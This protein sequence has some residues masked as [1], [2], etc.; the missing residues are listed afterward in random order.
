MNRIARIV[1][2]AA[3]LL[4]G[5]VPSQ[6]AA[7]GGGGCHGTPLTDDVTDE[8]K[9]TDACFVPTVARVRPGAKVTFYGEYME[10]NVTGVP[11]SFNA[12]QNQHILRDGT[13]LAFRFDKPGTYPYV[14]TL[15]PMMAGVIV[16]GDG[17]PAGGKTAGDGEDAAAVPPVGK[18]A[19][20]AAES[21]TTTTAVTSTGWVVPGALIVA[22]VV[23]GLAALLL[24]RGGFR[25]RSATH[26]PLG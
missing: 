22:L 14:C 25:R 4:G 26:A 2:V 12:L 17:V 1:M 16:V 10:H 18:G 19:P 9:A 20:P 11:T 8:I 6:P 13:P 15:H 21:S 23:M 7:A 3:L 5:L 24:Q